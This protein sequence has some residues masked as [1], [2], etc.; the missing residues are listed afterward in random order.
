MKI[1]NFFTLALGGVLLVACSGSL[2][3]ATKPDRY[4]LQYLQVVKPI[5]IPLNAQGQTVLFSPQEITEG[6]TLFEDNCINCHV[7]GNSLQSPTISLSSIDLKQATPPRDNL[8]ALVTFMKA[9]RTYNGKELSPTCRPADFLKADDL[10]KLGAFILRA[11]DRAK[12]WA[13]QTPD[14]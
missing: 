1:T 8:V 3:T 5:E 12:G 14:E 7:G 10:D 11:A 2:S 9:P 13:T 6:K 4:V